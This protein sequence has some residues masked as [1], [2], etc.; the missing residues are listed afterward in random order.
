MVISFGF[1]NLLPSLN[2]YLKANVKSLRLAI[3][4]GSS[5]PLLLYFL[6]ECVILGL[7]PNAGPD[8][9]LHAKDQGAMATQLLR[10]AVGQSWIMEVV[11]LFAFFAIVTSFV[12]VALSLLDFLADLFHVKRTPSGRLC[13]ALGVIVPPFICALTYPGAFLMALNYAGSLGAAILFGVLPALMVWK[14][15]YHLGLKGERLLPGGRAALL[16]I[17][18]LASLVVS[19]IFV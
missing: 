13:L 1:H 14:G 4:L 6:W 11:E 7:L 19:A 5:L 18:L 8:V 17:M 2:R 3:I 10:D 9:F 15:R 12:G 16:V